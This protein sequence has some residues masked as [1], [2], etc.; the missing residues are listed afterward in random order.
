MLIAHYIRMAL[1]Q[2]RRAPVLSIV[3]VLT[4]AAGLS[5]FLIA[6]AFAHYWASA[7]RHFPNADRIHVLTT[8]W[9]LRDGSFAFENEIGAARFVAGHLRVDFPDVERIARASLLNGERTVSSDQRTLQMTVLTAD[10]DFL[11]VFDLP[12]LAGDMRRA[13]ES[14]LSVVLT[15]DAAERL[16]GTRSVLGRTLRLGD[17]L[18]LTVTGVIDA[19]REPSHLGRSPQAPLG[20]DLLASHDVYDTFH[21]V[22]VSDSDA[23]G[24]DQ[25]TLTT[26]RWLDTSS[27]TYLLLPT[28]GSLTAAA[29]KARVA[30]FAERHMPAEVRALAR[31]EFDLI[32]VTALLGESVNQ[33]LF[34]TQR[35]SVSSVL[36][37]LGGLVLA[38]ACVNYASLA[39]ARAMRRTREAGLRKA[40]GARPADVTLQQLIEAVLLTAAALAIALI[41]LRMSGPIL[42]N[43]AGFDPG[44][45][46]FE[47]A[48]LPFVTVSI[49]LIVAAAAGA[50][51][52]LAVSRVPP[53]DAIRGSPLRVGHGR[54]P[55]LMVGAQ[56]VGVSFLLIAV[57]V[58]W[59]QNV[60][61]ERS[62]L[63]RTSDPLLII[64]NQSAQTGVDTATLRTEL[65]RIPQVTGVTGIANVPWVELGAQRISLDPDPASPSMLVMSRPVGPDFFAVFDMPLIAGRVP[66][67][68][69]AGDL[70]P[71]AASGLPPPTGFQNVVVD[72]AFLDQFGFDAPADALGAML[73]SSMGSATLV[74]HFRIVAVVDTVPWSVLRLFDARATMYAVATDHPYVIARV[75]ASDVSGALAEI[76]AAWERLTPNLPVDRRFLDDAFEQ[77]FVTFARINRVVMAIALIAFVIATAGLVAM[78][79][80][81]AGRRMREVAIRKTHGAR[82]GAMLAML[83]GSFTK[84]VL[85]ANLIAWP[86]AWI[87]ASAYLEVFLNPIRLTALPFV[88]CLAFTLGIAWIAVGGQ[89]LRAARAR[90]AEVLRHE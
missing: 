81:V 8:S 83:L 32:P 42:R 33:N 76:D 77:A 79:T 29:M 11:H 23:S 16:L 58:V 75:T 31:F 44:P 1:I 72:R 57:A 18:D 64:E 54:L 15:A 38:V 5:C 35:V 41:A 6:F 20:F 43:M 89:T 4:L 51:P 65:A 74:Q 78:G 53:M 87:A 22:T 69:I 68:E 36:L 27:T 37:L 47:S 2:I 66:D 46:L 24:I 26:Y 9:S 13:L 45:I 85:V 84:P 19:I 90:V 3:N 63:G 12:F 48:A 55:M 28:D 14:P 70:P 34:L 56:F 80:L 39:A 88:L 10:A 59:M 86:L 40:L 60:E 71:P 7:D 73:Y 62:G 50:L 17:A 61:L 82:T 49:A 30:G 25:A 52:A 67:P 21:P